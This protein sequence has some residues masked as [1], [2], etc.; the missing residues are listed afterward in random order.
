MSAGKGSMARTEPPHSRE[1]VPVPFMAPTEKGA[2]VVEKAMEKVKE[3]IPGQIPGWLVGVAGAGMMTV[4]GAG[5]AAWAASH[6]IGLGFF[7]DAAFVFGVGMTAI[8]ALQ[9]AIEL[10]ICAYYLNTATTRV[11]L[12]IAADHLAK[13]MMLMGTEAVFAMLSAGVSAVSRSVRAVA[14][15]AS[16]AG[17]LDSHFMAFKRLAGEMRVVIIVRNTNRRCLEWMAQG[18]PRKPGWMWNIKTSFRNT[19]LA[20]ADFNSPKQVAE[21]KKALEL[22]HYVVGQD[23]VPRNLHGVALAF[24]K[25][26]AWPVEPGQ[27][28]DGQSV[29]NGIPKAF[30]GDY[31]MLGVIHPYNPTSA[32]PLQHIPAG[33]GKTNITTE[34]ALEVQR[35]INIEVGEDVVMHGPHE[36]FA[37]VGSAGDCTAFFD[38]GVVESFSAVEVEEL[39]RFWGRPSK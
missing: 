4:A 37:P 18:F 28:I 33:W 10:Q 30:V 6:G 16:R 34:A 11:E 35:R 29:K 32:G 12:D 3:Q 17:M 27:I 13:A 7:L 20:T 23:G 36:V 24:D 2:I 25:P 38:D 1:N 26:P 8:T 21:L 15:A 14:A 39:F 19:G 5:I 9:G 22:G 31:D